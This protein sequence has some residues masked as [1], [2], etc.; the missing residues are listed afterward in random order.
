MEN[1]E[2]VNFIETYI[3]HCVKVMNSTK[4][5]DVKPS[6]VTIAQLLAEEA[7][8]RWNAIV[9]EEDVMVDDISVVVI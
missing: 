3:S 6:T 4:V 5:S 2:V 7:R 1:V 9:E 8:V